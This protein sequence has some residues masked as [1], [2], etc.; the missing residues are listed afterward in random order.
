MKEKAISLRDGGKAVP[1]M[2]SSW[3]GVLRNQKWL[4]LALILFGYGTVR[5]GLDQKPDSTGVSPAFRG[6]SIE[7]WL[8]LPDHVPVK[9]TALLPHRWISRL[10]QYDQPHYP[11]VLGVP[12]WAVP[13]V[14]NGMELVDPLFGLLD[15]NELPVMDLAN[16]ETFADSTVVMPFPL[17]FRTDSVTSVRP[18]T[19]IYYRTG[20][21]G[22]SDVDVQ[23][24]QRL[25]SNQAFSLAANF[26]RYDGIYVNSR[27]KAQKLRFFLQFGLP[28]GLV[29][30]YRVLGN[31]HRNGFPGRILPGYAVQ[32]PQRLRIVPRQDHLLHIRRKEKTDWNPS[33]DLEYHRISYQYK[34]IPSTVISNARFDWGGV[35]FGLHPVGGTLWGEVQVTGLR[36]VLNSRKNSDIRTRLVLGFQRRVRWK[37][38]VRLFI[39]QTMFLSGW[40]GSQVRFDVG[41]EIKGRF[42]PTFS[43]FLSRS[44]PPLLLRDGG[45]LPYENQPWAVSSDLPDSLLWGQDSISSPFKF[46]GFVLNIS[47]WHLYRF[48]WLISAAF[49]RG[50]E[51]PFPL[52]TADSLLHWKSSNAYWNAGIFL[53]WFWQPGSKLVLR[54][55]YQYWHTGAFKIAPFL[56]VPAHRAYL[57][58]RGQQKFFSGN[59]LV[60]AVVGLEYFT[61]RKSVLLEK[62][63]LGKVVELPELFLLHSRLHFSV[64][65]VQ[66]F[67][68]WQNLFNR[69]YS[70]RAGYLVPG[71]QFHYGVI[72]KLWD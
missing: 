6:F 11:A 59:L 34:D 65:D 20:D 3:M 19:R 40:K 22:L 69:A 23:F 8:Y 10:P 54:G 37:Y 14:F 43:A 16:V 51:Y 9:W 7:E 62:V 64:G 70:M 66:I 47:R 49:V 63:G 39:S 2:K 61:P 13:V 50:K 71:W 5:A 48:S 32:Y 28:F 55:T 58:L 56:E 29:G 18:Y 45:F 53:R 46:H 12:S 27:V 1:A 17:V 41:R 24:Q 36:Y 60:T 72:W 33:L 15:L 25:S 44:V 38:R 42:S 30:E 57:Q 67:L 26:L 4:I 21:N 68:Q 31:A 52:Q 35:R